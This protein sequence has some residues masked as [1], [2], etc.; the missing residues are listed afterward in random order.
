MFFVHWETAG[1]K[2]LKKKKAK[3]EMEGREGI[4]IR[5]EMN[6]IETGGKA[7]RQRRKRK[8]KSVTLIKHGTFQLHALLSRPGEK[9]FP[10]RVKVTCEDRCVAGEFRLGTV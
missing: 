1:S 6:E 2:K 4:P 5:G 9:L 10:A 7:G 8:K 3:S